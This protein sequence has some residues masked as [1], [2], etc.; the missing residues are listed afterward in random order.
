MAALG[1]AAC[2]SGMARTKTTLL[3]TV[4]EADEALAKQVTYRAPGA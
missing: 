1:S 2:S 4:A 3:L